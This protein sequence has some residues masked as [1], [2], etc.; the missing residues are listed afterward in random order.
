MTGAYA[1]ISYSSAYDVDV[2]VPP[3]FTAPRVKG[4]RPAAGTAGGPQS[5][6]ARSRR[7]IH[8]HQFYVPPNTQDRFYFAEPCAAFDMRQAL[9]RCFAQAD[10]TIG[11]WDIEVRGAWHPGEVA[12]QNGRPGVPL[13]PEFEGGWSDLGISFTSDGSITK[14]EIP[15]AQWPQETAYL[16]IYVLVKQSPPLWTSQF[17]VDY[18]ANVVKAHRSEFPEANVTTALNVDMTDMRVDLDTD[19]VIFI[20]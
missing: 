8:T 1:G 20:G 12:L 10:T 14:F 11:L 18:W 3:V 13:G 7:R 4:W 2:Y 19:K 17:L 5:L 9:F 16:L 6:L 15:E